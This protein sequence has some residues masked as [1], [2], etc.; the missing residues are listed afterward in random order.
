MH[1]AQ[2]AAKDGGVLGIGENGAAIDQPE[3]SH[4]AV[5][6]IMFFIVRAARRRQRPQLL[7][8]V[9]VEQLRKAFARRALAFGVL[10]GDAV[11]AAGLQRLRATFAQPKDSGS[12]VDI[13][14]LLFIWVGLRGR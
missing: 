1:L 9:G 6:G 7:K 8:G 12:S 3:A 4:N 11:G 13:E 10:A 2:R 14:S 5:A